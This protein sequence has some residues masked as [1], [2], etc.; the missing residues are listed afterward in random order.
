MIAFLKQRVREEGIV[1]SEQVLN[2][3]TLINQQVD[4]EFAMEAG[5][6]I[7]SRF[8]D[9]GVTK[10]VTIESSGIPMAMG[11]ALELGVSFTFARKKRTL[12]TDQ[13]VWTERVPSYTK[14][15]VTDLILNKALIK[16]EDKV[17][18]IDDL[19]ANG[20]GARGLVRI[21]NQTGAEIVGFGIVIEKMFQDGGKSL[22]EQGLHVESLVQIQSLSDGQI[23]FVGE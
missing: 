10:I 13:D 2:L 21:M 20:D 12:T 11:A 1:V 5:K 6:L 19:I 8:K 22:R 3:D 4:P 15:I 23:Q 14:G 7:A 9:A 17:L 16:P 18:L